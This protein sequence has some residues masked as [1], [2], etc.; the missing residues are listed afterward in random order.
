MSTRP[1]TREQRRVF[2]GISKSDVSLD[3]GI[4]FLMVRRV[5]MMND[6]R[7]NALTESM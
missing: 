2:V 5:E 6:E 3:G 7:A 4:K 1:K